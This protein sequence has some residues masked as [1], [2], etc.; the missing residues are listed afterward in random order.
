MFTELNGILSQARGLL[1]KARV[2]LP[3]LFI[4]SG[5]GMPGASPMG[6][7][8]FLYV[9]PPVSLVPLPPLLISPSSSSHISSTDS[10]T[11]IGICTS[12]LVVELSGATSESRYCSGGSFSF[13]LENTLDGTYSYSLVQMNGAGFASPEVSFIWTRD[14]VAPATPVIQA[15]SVSPYLSNVSTLTLSGTC[16]SG[17]TV[18]LGDSGA[19][20]T[21]CVSGSFSFILSQSTDGAHVYRISQRDSAGNVSGTASLT[22]NRDSTPPAAPQVTNYASPFVSNASNLTLSGTC[23]TGSQVTL[24]GAS[25]TGSTTCVGGGFSITVNKTLDG[26]YVFSLV[27]QDVAGNLSTT[28]AFTW[29]RD[30]GATP[31]PDLQSPAVNP[32]YSAGSSLTLSGACLVG[33]TVHVTGAHAASATCSS[34]SFS[35]PVSKSVDGNYSFAI[36]QVNAAGTASSPVSFTW[37]RDTVAPAPVVITSASTP[38]VN[39]A[40]SLTLAGSCEN[41]ATVTLSG[42]GTGVTTCSSSSFSFTVSKTTDGAY[43]FSVLQ[44]DASSNSSSPVSFSW[45]RDT[46]APSA[47]VILS[48]VSPY[49]GNAANLTLAGS[50]E[51]GASV[52]LSGDSIQSA[53]CASGTFSFS[54]S[55]AVDGSFSFSLAQ[56]DAAQN[57]SSAVSFSWTRDTL[58]P[59]KPTVVNPATASVVSNASSLLISGACESGATVNLSGASSQSEVCASSSYSFT[60]SKA[61]DGIYSFSVS[62][63][64]S[65]GNSSAP[66]GI[67][68]ERDTGIPA[69]P[70]VTS[71]LSPWISNSVG[72]TLVGTCESGAMVTVFGDASASQTCTSGGFSI[73]LSKSTDGNYSLSLTQSDAA[74]NVSPG[75]SFTWER[76]TTAPGAP[77]LTSPA[78]SPFTSSDT[79]LTI[80]G[81]CESGATVGLTGSATGSVICSSGAFSFSVSKSVDAT[82]QFSLSQM[83]AAGNVSAST[84]L[85]WVRNSIIPTT[86]V[87]TSPASNPY[88]SPESSLTLTGTC[89]S[90]HTVEWSGSSSGTVACSGG[91]SFT[92]GLSVSS[93]G[94]YSYSIRQ[95]SGTG[96]YSGTATFTW[97][98]DT[99][100]PVTPVITTPA[101]SP[102]VSNGNTL[103]V[104]GSCTAGLVLT[105]TGDAPLTTTTCSAGGSFSFSIPGSSDGNYSYQIYQTDLAGNASASAS[106]SWTRDTVSPGAVTLESPA[107]NPYS[108]GDTSMNLSGVCE[109]LATVVLSGA[110]SA[111]V[112]CSSLGYYSFPISK[113]ADGNYSYQIQ[114]TDA[115]GN[116]SSA[117][118]FLWTRDT[119]VPLTPLVSAPASNPY[120][121]SATNATFTVTCD[122]SLGGSVYLGGDVVGSEVVTPAG[123]AIQSCNSSP[124]T[125][126]VSKPSDGTYHLTFSQDNPTLGTN[127]ADASFTWVKDSTAPAVPS[128]INPSVNPYIAPGNLVVSGTCEP[129]SS[130]NLTGSSV[131]NTTCSVSGYFSMTVNKSSDG[132]YPFSLNQ[133]DSAG[134][135][136][137]S[138]SFTWG[139]NSSAIAPPG[140]SSP[141]VSPMTNNAS[142]YTLSGTCNPGY[143]IAPTGI[144]ASDVANPS[145]V[146]VQT[147]PANG[148]FSYQI[149]K[150]VDGTYALSLVQKLLTV[151]SSAVGRTWVRDT[152]APVVTIASKPASINVATA[153][154]FVLS[155]NEVGSLFQCKLDSGAYAACTSPVTYSSLINGSHTFSV[156]A[157]DAAG[158]VSGVQS[159]T[160]TQAAYNTM[161][162]YRFNGTTAAAKWADSSGYTTAG[163]NNSLTGTV[164]QSSSSSA[165]ASQFWNDT[166][167]QTL[168]SVREAIAFP[169]ATPAQYLSAASNDSLNLGTDNLTVEGWFKFTNLPGSGKYLTLVSKTGNGTAGNLYSWDFRLAYAS[170]GKYYFELA[171][172]S[173]GT[174][175][176]V[177]RATSSSSLSVSTTSSVNWYYIAMTKSG[178]TVK[179]Y[180]L[181][182]TSTSPSSYTSSLNSGSAVTQL[183]T[184]T[185]PIKI[186]ANASTVAGGTH[187]PFVGAVDELRISQIVRDVGTSANASFVKANQFTSD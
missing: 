41:G 174:S 27:Q 21:S 7:S 84:G 19:G 154:A 30:S 8:T 11:L 111:S 26:V 152:A 76:D 179:F 177:Y 67:S 146:L 176:S 22:W 3:S 139:R 73:G 83:D 77:G 173:N 40:S 171:A 54:V 109:P 140:I 183:A 46:A 186:G 45:Q 4:L 24:S 92:I 118:S 64:D 65:A 167:G 178:S 149:S 170:N 49:V 98:R 89:S 56:V 185:A 37:I 123:S 117:L 34:G 116:A 147:C 39:N 181:K 80:S 112:T 106:T 94:A 157:T 137:P 129:N 103:A 13:T 165:Q 23:E 47:P 99:V 135:T 88:Y 180:R 107:T 70:V 72:L 122:P 42:A 53:T 113:S 120:F 119:S 86:P 87:V 102:K 1:R 130:V 105:L 62:Q 68:W 12:G 132:S 59:A 161:A 61:T 101:S 90:G 2:A 138:V 145:G 115:S 136:S 85:Q 97:N 169:T 57:A 155:S 6:D 66:A 60:V 153:S 79:L 74:G 128:L 114:Q 142:T 25:S 131:Q 148:S 14:T 126:V 20:S 63:T 10:I 151:S 108:S 144:S 35:F 134:N 110:G 17:A 55:K 187:I 95:K 141:L 33:A 164:T 166:T 168:S 96:V 50:C 121:S 16:E 44:S 71:P 175:L 133:T 18:V 93:D 52:K 91:G 5:C 29:Q 156:K 124:V 158:N 38:L 43:S 78:S 48:P 9:A 104:A 150:S 172:S 51:S 28:S 82:Y 127:S 81:T 69:A 160:W 15:P 182:T 159:W 162:L 184:T 31:A 36:H 143:D 75:A 58:V 163:F 125:F 32:F 100:P